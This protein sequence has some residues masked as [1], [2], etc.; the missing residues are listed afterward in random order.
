MQWS[1]LK[2][3]TMKSLIFFKELGFSQIKILNYNKQISSQSQLYLQKNNFKSNPKIPQ[4]F[5][6]CV[7]GN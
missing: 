1:N 4:Y 7:H 5:K 2:L 6:I 3:Y